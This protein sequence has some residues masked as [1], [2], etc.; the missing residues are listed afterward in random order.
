MLRMTAERKHVAVPTEVVALSPGICFVEKVRI[1]KEVG[2]KPVF[3]RRLTL[4]FGPFS[5]LSAGSS[6]P[7]S[8]LFKENLDCSLNLAWV[9]QIAACASLD[10]LLEG[11]SPAHRHI[12]RLFPRAPISFANMFKAGDF[13]SLVKVLLVGD[14]QTGKTS[15]LT[16]YCDDTF[17]PQY[18]STIGVDFK[19]HHVDFDGKALKMQIWDTAGPERFRTITSAYYRGSHAILFVYDSTDA[20]TFAHVPNWLAQA[21][22]YGNNEIVRMLVATKCDLVEKRAV[23][24]QQGMEFAAQHNLCFVETSAKDNTNVSN[25]FLVTAIDAA[26]MLIKRRLAERGT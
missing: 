6:N 13:D 26:D 25:L 19:I 1:N 16:R 14:G 3:H 15:L 12:Q 5:F 10:F 18:V 22:M 8:S 23:S 2:R 24:H 17:R 11:I 9:V 20:A 4:L 21:A 7:T